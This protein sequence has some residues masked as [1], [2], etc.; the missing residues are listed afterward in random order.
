MF[1]SPS[2]FYICFV[3]VRIT[4]IWTDY[5]MQKELRRGFVGKEGG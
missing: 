3:L 2:L 4:R 1:A 5:R